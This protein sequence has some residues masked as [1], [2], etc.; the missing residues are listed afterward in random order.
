MN[1]YL[2][3]IN[4]I[5]FMLMALIPRIAMGESARDMVLRGNAAYDA[6]KYD[7]ALSAYEEAAG[8]APDSSRII[9]NKGT[10]HYRKGEYQK[11]IEA[12]QE[13]GQK[14]ITDSLFGAYT[15]FNLGNSYFQEA[16]Q[17]KQTDQNSALALYGKSIRNFQEALELSPDLKESAENIEIA[18]LAMKS[19]LEQME[20]E[21]QSDEKQQ[22]DSSG[23]D[24]Q[25]DGNRQDASEKDGQQEENQ[26]ESS[27][28][29]KQQ[30]QEKQQ[31]QAPQPQEQGDQQKQ[32]QGE[33]QQEQGESRP[34]SETGDQ[35]D[36]TA[37]LSEDALDILNEE[38]E[39]RKHRR[40]IQMEDDQGV[41]R[42]W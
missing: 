17:K 31:G 33:Q 15:K 7:E 38:K 3:Y 22:Q 28:D 8:K 37:Q 6:G 14:E 11:A 27:G 16:E 2:R 12:F 42:D 32:E 36:P 18:R 34:E 4:A 20:K 9:F 10:A 24:K 39:N 13:A 26:Q 5:I 19:L 21:R 25:Q 40:M 1:G 41:E 30:A 35:D 29:E 23:E